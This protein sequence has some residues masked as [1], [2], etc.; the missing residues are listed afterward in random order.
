[1]VLATKLLATALTAAY[2]LSRS[3]GKNA[4]VYAALTMQA[5]TD[6]SLERYYFASTLAPRDITA[7][8]AIEALGT[9][10]K[11]ARLYVATES[12]AAVT[13]TIEFQKG[14]S[15]YPRPLGAR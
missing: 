9:N 11:Q 5:V 2:N 13:G 15:P 6:S 8:I 10:T 12:V 3:S 14:H 1:M 7:A 4:Y